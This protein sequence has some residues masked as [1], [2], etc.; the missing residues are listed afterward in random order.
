VLTS[1][2]YEWCAPGVTSE[3][4]NPRLQRFSLAELGFQ[5]FEDALSRGEP[6]YGKTSD[7]PPEEQTELRA[8]E[9]E[10]IACV[11]ILVRGEWWGYVGFDDCVSGR[12]W[13]PAEIGALQAAAGILGAVLGR[14]RAEEAL[15]ASEATKSALTEIIPDLMFLVSPDGVF[16]DYKGAATDLAVPPDEIV[17][18]TIEDLLPAGIARAARRGTE[19]ALATGELQT[20][21]YVL[22]LGGEARA[23]EARLVASGD[24]NVLVICRDITAR[25]RAE[26]DRE[27]LLASERTARAEAEDARRELAAQNERLVEVDRLKDELVATVSHELRT[28][29]TSI[30]GYVELLRDEVGTGLDGDPARYLNVVDRNAKRLLTVVSDLLLVAQLQAGTLALNRAEVDLDR[31][32]RECVETFAPRARAREVELVVDAEAV[33]PLEADRARLGQLLDNLVSNGIKFTPEGGRVEVRTRIGERG[34]SV[35]VFVSD[36]GVGIPETEQGRL[37]ERFFRSQTA[38][39]LAVQGIGL[40]L[41]IAK[42]IVDAHGGTIAVESAEGLGTTVR[43]EL[44]VRAEARSAD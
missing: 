17:G 35:L 23:F 40:G 38:T 36:T 21:D 44:P 20:F 18:R 28:P 6:V 14:R 37:F 12:D 41:V 22:P 5:R 29:L 34:A 15:R 3:I 42:A 11:P 24:G 27:R 19:R 8:Q 43:V 39:R 26:A 30:L 2:R 16:V 9:V 32:V 4:A 33:P 7:F 10:A 31:L 13:A 1:Q 25:K